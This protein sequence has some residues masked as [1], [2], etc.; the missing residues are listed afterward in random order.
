MDDSPSQERKI[1]E[2]QVVPLSDRRCAFLR[3][4]LELHGVVFP[5]PRSADGVIPDAT[6]RRMMRRAEIEASP[7]GFHS[8]FRT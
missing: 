5:N 4:T 3:R 7:H 2:D 8:T 1:K 6:I